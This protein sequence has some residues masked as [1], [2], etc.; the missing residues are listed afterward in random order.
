MH[1][2]GEFEREG[3]KIDQDRVLTYS[4]LRCP[5]DCRYCFVDDM[6]FN[7]QKHV[8]YLSEKQQELIEE[9][10]ENVN[11]IMLGCDTEFFQSK[12]GALAVLER[13]ARQNRDISVITKLSLN[14]EYI[15]QLKEIDEKLR[16]HN[17]F[18]TFSIS[19]PCWESAKV[20]EPKAPDPQSRAQTL[21]TAHQSGIQ[22]LL[23]LRPLLPTIPDEELKEIIDQTAEYT[24]GYYSGPLYLK[25]LDEELV[26]VSVRPDLFIEHLQPHWMPDG[27]MFY[28]IEKSGQMDVLRGI[29][30]SHE[31]VLFEGAAEA[32][33]Y[34]KQ[35]KK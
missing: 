22:T 18:L 27:N 32:I 13:L 30:S 16:S 6:N 28:K 20:W 17:N 7:Q 26:P 2:A 5:L 14:R 8:S 3:L 21:K 29:V 11:L 12:R 24:D 19:I 31:K 4:Q 25:E 10:P 35:E 33:E 15:S 23:A 34:L 1:E 9:L